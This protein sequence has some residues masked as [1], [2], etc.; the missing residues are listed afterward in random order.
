[1]KLKIE[2]SL[3][4]AAFEE[5]FGAEIDYVLDQVT[6]RLASYAKAERSQIASLRDSNGNTVGTW[7]ITH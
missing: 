6:D 2:I 7:Q 5:D 1:M 3:D 4:N